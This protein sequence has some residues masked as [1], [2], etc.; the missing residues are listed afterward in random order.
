MESATTLP[1][2]YQ[3][4]LY[5]KNIKDF[6]ISE[7]CFPDDQVPT[8]ETFDEFKEKHFMILVKISVKFFGNVDYTIYVSVV[9][10]YCHFVI[11][12]ENGMYLMDNNEIHKIVADYFKKIDELS[13]TQK[14]KHF[15]FKEGTH[16]TQTI[17]SLAFFVALKNKCFGNVQK[18]I[19]EKYETEIKENVV[20]IFEEKI[21]EFY[22]D[23]DE[24]VLLR[25]SSNAQLYLKVIEHL[26][27]EFIHLFECSY[28]RDKIIDENMERIVFCYKF[29]KNK[30]VKIYYKKNPCQIFHQYLLSLFEVLDFFR[31]FY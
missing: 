12:D 28:E 5:L 1:F 2:T 13:A 21:A 30:D 10:G 14:I 7:L 9:Y 25:Y 11:I 20:E 4:Y 16:N 8:L 15:I 18:M 3:D 29:C 31:Y 6:I 22:A 26:F 17:T 27:D 24:T 23:N 19:V